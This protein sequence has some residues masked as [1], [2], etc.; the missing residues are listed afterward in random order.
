MAHVCASVV[1]DKKHMDAII[2]AVVSQ[3]EKRK[4]SNF[5]THMHNQDKSNNAQN[6]KNDNEEGFSPSTSYSYSY[7]YSSAPIPPSFIHG[8][9]PSLRHLSARLCY[10]EEI[11]PNQ[12]SRMSK[13]DR[14]RYD[15]CG[16]HRHWPFPYDLGVYVCMLCA[17][18]MH[19]VRMPY[20]LVD[21]Y[22]F[23]AAHIYVHIIYS[24]I[25]NK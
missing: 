9:S 19:V 12:L 17:C 20:A 24:S 25:L 2:H 21:T 8:S 22:T 11:G 18:Y 23:T 4:E 16:H 1:A 10:G 6:D 3:N 15:H 13:E 14:E 5:H 7:S